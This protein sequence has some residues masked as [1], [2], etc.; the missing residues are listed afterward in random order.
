MKKPLDFLLNDKRFNLRQYYF[1]DYTPEISI[2]VTVHNMGHVIYSHLESTLNNTLSKCEFLIIDD[3]SSDDSEDAIQSFIYYAATQR[4]NTSFY[5]TRIPMYETRCEDFAIQKAKGTFILLVQ[6]DMKILESAYDLRLIRI[7]IDNPALFAVS[8]RGVHDFNSIN[9]Q[10]VRYGREIQD[11]LL[12][13]RL[14]RLLVA[15]RYKLRSI[16]LRHE[17]VNVSPTPLQLTK[18]TYYPNASIQNYLEYIFPN[19]SF[20]KAG[21]TSSLIELLPYQKSEEVKSIL[22]SKAGLVWLGETIMRGPVFFRALDYVQLGGFNTR[23]FYQGL[24]DH[25]LN[26][27]VCTKGKKVGFTPILFSAPIKIGSMRSKKS[28]TSNLWSNLHAYLRRREKI[29]SELYQLLC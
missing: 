23:A 28:F 13:R 27:R 20:T 12:P 22:D 17:K 11:S 9:S 18:D 8:C 2:I 3:C 25:D 10:T 6:S 14:R 7:L 21:F 26:V 24:D 16:I 15:S 19:S 4:V 29:R 5:F 1:F